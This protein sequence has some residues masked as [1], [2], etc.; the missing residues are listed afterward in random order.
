MRSLSCNIKL[1]LVDDWIAAAMC[2]WVCLRNVYLRNADA[3]LF[4]H[5][6]YSQRQ[7]LPKKQTVNLVHPRLTCFLGAPV[8]Y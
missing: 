2:I 8:L 6:T 4:Q 7:S 3:F 1:L 5:G